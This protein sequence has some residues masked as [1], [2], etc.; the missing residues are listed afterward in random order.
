MK[1]IKIC[2]YCFWTNKIVNRKLLKELKEV[3]KIR[4]TEKA[5]YLGR[6]VSVRKDK[7]VVGIKSRIILC[8]Y[9]AP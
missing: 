7:I 5:L 9:S 1:I 8:C 4:I 2:I 6:D 3:I